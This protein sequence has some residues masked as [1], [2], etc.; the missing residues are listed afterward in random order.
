MQHQKT[1]KLRTTQ[2]IKKYISFF[3]SGV[4]ERVK[5]NHIYIFYPEVEQDKHIY[6]YVYFHCKI[7]II[8]IYI[9]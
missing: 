3:I 6:V 9:K 4:V 5:V 1:F 2:K 8:I 7:I